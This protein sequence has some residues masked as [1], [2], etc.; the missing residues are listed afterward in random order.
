MISE[1]IKRQV[2]LIVYLHEYLR[3]FL[4]TENRR[5]LF[6]KFQKSARTPMMQLNLRPSLHCPSFISLI[7]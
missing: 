2:S 5:G 7:T 3:Y 6:E 1:D 4:Q